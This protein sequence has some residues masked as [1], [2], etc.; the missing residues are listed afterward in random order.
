M[1]RPIP[2]PTRERTID[3]PAA[4]TGAWM[5]WDM[6]PRRLPGWQAC[7]PAI[8]ASWVVVSSFCAIGVIGPTGKVRAASATQPS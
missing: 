8:S 5:A 4:S 6:S 1:L 3:N 7:T 2:C